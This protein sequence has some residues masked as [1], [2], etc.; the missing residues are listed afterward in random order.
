MRRTIKIC[1]AVASVCISS[2]AIICAGRRCVVPAGVSG[3]IFQQCALV[4]PLRFTSLDPDCSCKELLESC[5][6]HII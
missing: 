3:A 2:A 5:T 4:D 6:E 1:E